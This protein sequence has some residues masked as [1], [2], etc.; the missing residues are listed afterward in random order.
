[1]LPLMSAKT[2]PVHM[3]SNPV[4]TLPGWV[5]SIDVL[6]LPSFD[7]RDSHLQQN[8]S[9]IHHFQRRPAPVE[10]CRRGRLDIRLFRVE[11][12]VNLILAS[13]DVLAIDP[14]DH[15]YR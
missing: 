11:M 2:V 4:A 5:Q 13:Q 12:F 15:M 14:D 3:R 10:A 7:P 6:H 9:V 8:D 1:M